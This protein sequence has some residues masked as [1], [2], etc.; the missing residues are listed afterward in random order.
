MILGTG[1]GREKKIKRCPSFSLVSITL[2]RGWGEVKE[3]EE[4]E[5]ASGSH[6]RHFAPPR[7]SD[8][9]V[10]DTPVLW[11]GLHSGWEVACWWGRPGGSGVSEAYQIHMFI[12]LSVY[13]HSMHSALASGDRQTRRALSDNPA[14]VLS[15][16]SHVSH[17]ATNQTG[18]PPPPVSLALWTMTVERRDRLD[19][20]SW[21]QLGNPQVGW[22]E[23]L[24][25][26][27]CGVC[28]DFF[29]S[30]TSWSKP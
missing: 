10:W 25:I 13:L 1:T 14:G 12:M 6:S 28:G 30:T 4:E 29:F 27:H 11:S 21:K 2:V 7:Q 15:G 9:Q 5:P 18:R 3:E 20:K 16:L 24:L 8:W 22:R 19:I 26:F 17:R 23:I